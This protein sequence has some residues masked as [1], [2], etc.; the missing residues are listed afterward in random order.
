MNTYFELFDSCVKQLS[1]FT[2]LFAILI[3]VINYHHLPLQYKLLLYLLLY[4]FINDQVTTFL[5]TAQTWPLNNLYFLFEAVIMSI[6]LTKI[7]QNPVFKKIIRVAGFL[8]IAFWCITSFS[9][10]HVYLLEYNKLF[11]PVRSAILSFIAAIMIYEKSGRDD[12]LFREPSFWVLVA[13]FTYL[14]C[15][16]IVFLAISMKLNQQW[17]IKPIVWCVHNALSTIANLIY[18]YS[19]YLLAK[20]KNYAAG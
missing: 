5:P 14:F 3:G 18:A 16:M 10:P 19:F 2:P 7:E 11:I 8:I 9:N 17:D 6:I 12:N 4:G 13:F 1:K 15:N 20:R